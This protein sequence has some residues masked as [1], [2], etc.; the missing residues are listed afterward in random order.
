MLAFT[1]L[2]LHQHANFKSIWTGL[3]DSFYEEDGR[4]WQ[5]LVSRMSARTHREQQAGGGGA[6]WGLI[7]ARGHSGPQLGYTSHVALL[8]PLCTAQA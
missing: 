6:L 4:V 1:R 7:A 2:C 3:I 5:A 8:P